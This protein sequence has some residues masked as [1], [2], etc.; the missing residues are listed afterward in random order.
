MEG[1]KSQNGYPYQDKYLK[2]GYC[3]FRTNLKPILS[4]IRK[5]FIGLYE[6]AARLN[7]YEKSISCDEDI[8][9][10]Y[11]CD[12]R[13]I[14]LS[15]F[16]Q[17]EHLPEVHGL[18][19]EPEIID[20]VKSLGVRRPV[21]GTFTP[22]VRIDMPHDDDWLFRP[23]QD[24]AYNAGSLNSVNLWVPLQDI[25]PDY[26]PMSLDAGSH[27]NGLLDFDKSTGMILNYESKRQKTPLP[28]C[29]D[30][31]AFSQFLVHW[32]GANRTKKVRFTIILRYS[33]L[34]SPEYAGRKYYLQNPTPREMPD[35]NRNSQ[36]SFDG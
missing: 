26:G 22:N 15:L 5:S 8:D 32:S 6:T 2:E 20:L 4:E 30:I 9:E 1:G 11:H 28:M 21:I 31:L 10:L 18:T 7:G 24:I 25:T 3:C 35:F 27:L 16:H 13:D 23:H 29:G 12:Q 17:L 33:D 14:W 36:F 19:N 34:E